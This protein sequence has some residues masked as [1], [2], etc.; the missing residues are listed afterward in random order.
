MISNY[1]GL[2]KLVKYLDIKGFFEKSLKIKFVLKCT[3]KLLLGF[4]NSLK[5]TVFCR[6]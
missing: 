1:L 5:F 6:D 2:H 3:G 4:E